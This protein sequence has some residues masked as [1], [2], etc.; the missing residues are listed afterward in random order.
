VVLRS[1]VRRGFLALLWLGLVPLLTGCYYT[2]GSGL[3]ETRAFE[4]ADFDRVAI[5]SA[6]EAD[7]SYGET[8]DVSVTADAN[9]FNYVDVVRHGDTL[10]IGLKPRLTLR[11]GTLQAAVTLP[12]LEGIDASGAAS[13]SVAGFTEA[14]RFDA[15]ASGAS[16]LTLDTLTLG[17]SKFDISGASQLELRDL[18]ADDADFEVSGASRV[19]GVVSMRNGDLDASGASQITLRGSAGV[20]TIEGSGASN[21]SLDDLPMAGLDLSLSGA[22][23]GAVNVSGQ[24]DLDISG[25]STLYYSGSPKLGRVD[26]TGAST[27][28]QR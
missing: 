18:Y 20:L 9:L 1:R 26:V 16:R 15:G 25:A 7:V 28:V 5:S 23:R 10:Y 17:N 6:F 2:A 12:H 19:S 21:L 8:C 11:H 24:L 14:T 4:I 22:S 3:V 13:V 27:L